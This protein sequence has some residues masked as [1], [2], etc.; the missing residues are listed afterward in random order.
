MSKFYFGGGSGDVS[1]DDE[2]NLPYPEALP[3]SDFLAPTFD[4]PTYL[5]TLSDRHQTLEDLR[6]DLRE[7][8]QGLSK[9]LLDLVNTNY[10]QFLSLGSDLKGGE[11][12]VEDVRVG[13]LGFKRGVEDVRGKVRERKLEV[14]GLLDEKKSVTKEIALGRK[15]LEV[16]SRLEELED[17]LMVASLGRSPNGLEDSWSEDE[18]E[19]EDEDEGDLAIDGVVNG[20]S[21][22]RLQRFVLDYRNVEHLSITIGL[23]HPFIA[24]QQP[25]LLR[26]KNTIVLDLNN[27]LKQAMSLKVEGRPRLV[28]IMGIYR[29]LGAGDEAVKILRD[30]KS[31]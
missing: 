3:R 4:A 23:D 21:T 24:A 14:E 10:E 5:S 26:L 8:S 6:S 25:R 17:R 22:K 27:A 29:D 9:E 1:S 31:T 28:K 20:T 12:K 30:V 16:D 7:R 19:D 11:E 13:L 18:E 15:L 2:D